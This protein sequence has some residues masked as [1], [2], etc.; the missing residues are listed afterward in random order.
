MALKVRGLIW[1]NSDTEA[2]LFGESLR[3]LYSP[4]ASC[5][6]DAELG[7]D[8]RACGPKTARKKLC[9]CRGIIFSSRLTEQVSFNLIRERAVQ[10]WAPSSVSD[11]TEKLIKVA[12]GG[13]GK[14]VCNFHLVLK[15][16]ARFGD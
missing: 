10:G 3:F 15:L 11:S 9:I 6:Q 1:F 5:C 13:G 2:L 8:F 7:F 16:I 12:R 14:R 4:T